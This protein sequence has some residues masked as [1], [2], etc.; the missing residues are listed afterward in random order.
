L[1]KDRTLV[2]GEKER[3]KERRKGGGAEGGG[4]KGR[5]SI[6][7]GFGSRMMEWRDATTGSA[8]GSSEWG[9]GRGQGAGEVTA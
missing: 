7:L 3:R 9:G 1:R 5:F 2:S 8:V 4:G 6:R